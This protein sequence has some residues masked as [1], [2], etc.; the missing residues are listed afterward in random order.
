MAG[1]HADFWPVMAAKEKGVGSK[2]EPEARQGLKPDVHLIGY[3]GPAE[4]VPLLQSPASSEFS[5]AYTAA[6]AYGG[7]SIDRGAGF[8]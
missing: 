4:A 7:L 6:S 1:T 3:Y 8:P 2:G 5:A